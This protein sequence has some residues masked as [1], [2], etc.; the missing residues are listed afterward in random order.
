MAL[1]Y[2]IVA[3]QIWAQA[4]AKGV[5]DGATVDLTDGFIH[6]STAAQ[7]EDTAAK[8]FSGQTDLLVVAVDDQIFGD[9]LIY[10]VSRGGALF[11]HLYAGLRCDQA[12][13]VRPLPIRPDGAFDFSSIF[14]D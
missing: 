7:L 12:L 3:K 10:E 14:Q 9:K 5:F 13:F 8:H 6:F 11:P 2:K 4:E 1:I